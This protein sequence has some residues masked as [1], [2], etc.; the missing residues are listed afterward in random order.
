LK[1]TITALVT[2]DAVVFELERDTRILWLSVID[3]PTQRVLWKINDL[4]LSQG[5]SAVPISFPPSMSQEPE[6]PEKWNGEARLIGF[7]TINAFRGEGISLRKV[8]YGVVPAGMQQVLP[9]DS[10]PAPLSCGTYLL[11]VLLPDG[12]LLQ[13]IELSKA[14]GTVDPTE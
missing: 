1:T 7:S 8:T 11:S 13:T 12:V 9:D 14:F 5:K 6:N 3:Q 4:R 2:N 10:P